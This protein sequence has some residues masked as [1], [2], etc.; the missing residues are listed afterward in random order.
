MEGF[1]S[2]GQYHSMIQYS[3]KSRKCLLHVTE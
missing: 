2:R 1:T 3:S